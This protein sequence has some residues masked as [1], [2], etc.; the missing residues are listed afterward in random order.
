MMRRAIAIV[1]A[2]TETEGDKIQWR[3]VL[4]GDLYELANKSVG[5]AEGAEKG[6]GSVAKVVLLNGE[7]FPYKTPR[8]LEFRQ[9]NSQ[10][11]EVTLDI[12][13]MRRATQ[14]LGIG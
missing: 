13:G 8:G 10:G 7:S 4:Y 14:A 1:T 3:C 11:S 2:K 6:R 12:L 5:P 9:L